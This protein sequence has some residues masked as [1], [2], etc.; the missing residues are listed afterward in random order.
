[1]IDLQK[2]TKRIIDFRNKRHWAYG[3]AIAP[4]NMAIGLMLEAAELLE[5]FEW[6]KD[7]KLPSNRK[8]HLEEEL[9]DV[10]YWVLLIAY[11]QKIDIPKTF[12][13]K[14]KKNEV[15]YPVKKE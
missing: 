4:K 5:V 8:E 10:L 3:K 13:R 15:K 6:T 9:M 14:M 12:E 7:N 2:L 11:E 1:M